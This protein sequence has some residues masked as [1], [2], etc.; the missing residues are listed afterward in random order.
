MNKFGT[1]SLGRLNTC[2][3]D[4]VKIASL[5]IKRS[6]IDFGIAQGSR[7]W[8][9]QLDYYLQGKSKL[10]PRVEEN[11]TRAKHVTGNGWREL[12]EALDFYIYHPN[13]ELR[14][15][16]AYDRESLAYVAGVF[17][18]CAQELFEKGEVSHLIR[19]GGNWDRDG[20]ILHDQS[21][22]DMPHVELYKPI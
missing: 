22:D 6:R 11:K 5:A 17:V 9:Q 3:P 18:C 15:K 13:D 10:D 21:F 1:T 20:V 14:I 19:W 7:T 12:S 2:H 16:L 8:Q 4:M